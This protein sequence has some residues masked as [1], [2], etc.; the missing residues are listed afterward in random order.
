[1]TS[2]ARLGLLVLPGYLASPPRRLSRY[3]GSRYNPNFA[4]IGAGEGPNSVQPSTF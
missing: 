2:D 3:Y 4:A 1:M